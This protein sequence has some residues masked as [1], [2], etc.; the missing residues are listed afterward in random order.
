MNGPASDLP[1]DSI[2]EDEPPQ[3]GDDIFKHTFVDVL[4]AKKPTTETEMSIATRQPKDI[5]YFYNF[6]FDLPTEYYKQLGD[7]N[8]A[9]KIQAF[10]LKQFMINTWPVV[11]NFNFWWQFF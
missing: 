2:Q 11:S 8:I 10:K 9:N 7:F 6:N 1:V 5:F 4:E 3:N